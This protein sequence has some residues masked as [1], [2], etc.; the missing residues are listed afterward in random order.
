MSWVSTIEYYRLINEAVSEQLGSWHSAKCV[1]HSVDFAEVEALQRSGDW[2]AAGRLLNENACA[3][4]RAGADVLV[5]CT[6]TMHKA[7]T[8]IG[9]GLQIP[10]LHIARVT[11]EAIRHRGSEKVGLLGTAYTMEMDFYST[12]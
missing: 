8:E 1:I 11:G 9:A 2:D 6:N 12:P 5:L 3:L 10:F 7:A 4:E